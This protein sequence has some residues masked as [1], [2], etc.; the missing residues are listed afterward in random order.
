MSR[1]KAGPEQLTGADVTRMY[2]AKE[3]AEIE[4]ARVDGR[5]AD[6]LGQPRPPVGQV[7]EEHVRALFAEGR[8]A[9]IERLRQAGHLDDLLGITPTNGDTTDA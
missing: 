5:L 8:T 7:D 1:P 2:R 4:A 9:E 6:L 3:Y